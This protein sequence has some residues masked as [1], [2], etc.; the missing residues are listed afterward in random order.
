MALSLV[1]LFC[2]VVHYDDLTFSQRSYTAFGISSYFLAPTSGGRKMQ[3]SSNETT[4]ELDPLKGL[5]R[6]LTL[7]EVK[8]KGGEN[9]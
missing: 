6:L 1:S 7:V 2:L 5:T 9:Y 8:R 4:N 3:S